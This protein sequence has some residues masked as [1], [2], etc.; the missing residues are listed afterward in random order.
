MS[1]PRPSLVCLY[2]DRPIQVAGLKVLLLSLS[3]Y[4]PTWPVRLRFPGISPSFRHW[5]EQFDQVDLR[6][7]YLPLS[8]SFNVK[9][10]VLLDGLSTGAQMCLWLDTDVLV[11]GSLD[12]IASVPSEHI[13]VTQDPWEYAEG[14]THRCASWGMEKGRSLPGP[15][16]SAVVRVTGMHD[17][18]L[19]KW[20]MV[21]A[22]HNYMREQATPVDSRNAHMLG[23]QDALSA[24]LASRQFSSIPVRKLAHC[25]EILQHHG[26]GAYGV[27]QRWTNLAHGMPPLIHAMGSVKPWRMPEHPRLLGNLGDYYERTY[28]ELSPYV[29]FARFYRAALMESSTWLENQTWTS[30]IGSLLSLNRPWLK[31]LAQAAVHRAW[32]QLTGLRKFAKW[33]ASVADWRPQ[34]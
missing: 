6:D 10:T 3:Q 16:N 4:C 30:R 29:H 24:L 11:N 12:F 33:V 20:E 21:L 28:L 22:D 18:L 23:D 1:P 2:E 9:P 27:A 17:A 26:P 34:T 19:K 32:W 13:V 5:L 8:G 31:G 25:S 15:L 14:S 7:D